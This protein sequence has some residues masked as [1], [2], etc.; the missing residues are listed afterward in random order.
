MPTAARGLIA[1]ISRGKLEPGAGAR[2]LVARGGRAPRRVVI[3]LVVAG[4]DGLPPSGQLVDDEDVERDDQRRP[5]RLDREEAD[6]ADR[7]EAG[8]HDREPTCP[9]RAREERHAGEELEDAE[10]QEDPAPL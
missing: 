6:I 10:D 4:V 3:A 1:T 7:V 5:K 2:C 9:A 8:Q